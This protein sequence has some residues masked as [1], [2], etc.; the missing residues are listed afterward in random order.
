MQQA[1]RVLRRRGDVVALLALLVA[2]FLL[3]RG[4]PSGIAAIGVVAGVGVA[5]NALGVILVYRSTRIINF[6]QVAFGSVAAIWL[7]LWLEHLQWIVVLHKVCH[8]CVP[9]VPA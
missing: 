7:Y 6:A 1:L 3:P 8:A 5:L 9:Y 4:V 2:L